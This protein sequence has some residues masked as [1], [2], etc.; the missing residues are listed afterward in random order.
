M[1]FS[2]GTEPRPAIDLGFL[3]YILVVT[4]G[5][6]ALAACLPPEVT[7][8]PSPDGRLVA[9]LVEFREM[10]PLGSTD[11][12]VTVQA[13]Q[14]FLSQTKVVLDGENMDGRGFSSLNL[15]WKDSH[16]LVIGYCSGDLGGLI[17]RVRVGGADVDIRLFQ[18]ARGR[19]PSNIPPERR[20]GPPPCI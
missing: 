3:P 16:T 7:S 5:A 17:P 9:R 15:S 2:V 8:Y 19:W 20:T 1:F 11:Q 6:L 13:R 4:S 10:G 12:K 14:G 18:E